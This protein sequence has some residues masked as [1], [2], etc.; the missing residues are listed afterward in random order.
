VSWRDLP[1]KHAPSL[2]SKAKSPSA[3]AMP[4]EKSVI[5]HQAPPVPPWQTD[6][7]V[8]PISITPV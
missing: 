3:T 4:S 1:T 8:K 2:L 7:A 5:L 6:S